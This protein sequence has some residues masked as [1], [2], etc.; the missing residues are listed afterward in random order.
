M[1]L[2]LERGIIV[3]LTGASL[4]KHSLFWNKNRMEIIT[5]NNESGVQSPYS[6]QQGEIVHTIVGYIEAFF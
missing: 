3:H 4:K 5:L 1:R 6:T 2:Y